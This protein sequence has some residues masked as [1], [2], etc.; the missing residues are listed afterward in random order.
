MLGRSRKSLAARPSRKN[1][2]NNNL[3]QMLWVAAVIIALAILVKTDF[4]PAV[5]A[6]A[7]KA[8][9]EALAPRR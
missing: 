6:W 9:V 1:M 2:G 8:V 5:L 3:R 4:W 7:Q